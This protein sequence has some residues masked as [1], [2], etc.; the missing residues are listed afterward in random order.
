VKQQHREQEEI[1]Q[2]FDLLP[3]RSVERCE[4]AD[5]IAAQ[6]QGKIRKEELGKVHR[7]RITECPALP[8]AESHAGN[9]GPPFL[10]LLWVFPSWR[11]VFFEYHV[12]TF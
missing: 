10:G 2:T 11:Q 6:D 7:A 8:E 5:Q 1:N 12:G 4:T 9:M 3:N